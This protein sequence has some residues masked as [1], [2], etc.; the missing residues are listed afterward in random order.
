MTRSKKYTGVYYNTL[1][2]KDKSYYI[3][4]KNNSKKEW[5]KMGLHSEGIREA[6]CSKYRANLLIKLRL[7]DDAPTILKN[8]IKLT[9]N[10]I[11][12]DF[13]KKKSYSPKT[14]QSFWGRYINHI[15]PTLGEKEIT[16]ISDDD[17]KNLYTKNRTT[18]NLSKKTSQLTMEL[19][20]AII[21]HAIKKGNFTGTNPVKNIKIE[22]VD[23]ARE[24]YLS[25]GEIEIL[26]EQIKEYG[27]LYLFTLLSLSTGARLHD[28][29]ALQKKDFNLDNKTVTITNR[30]G[31]S[32]YQAFLTKRVLCTLNLSNLQH[33]DILYTVSERTIQRTLQNILNKLF[34]V[35]LDAK[36]AKN[37][38]VIHTLRHT[39]ASHLAIS[40][41][42]IYTIMK[43]MDHQ[44]IEDTLRYAKLS[45]ENGRDF[46]DGLF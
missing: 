41:T 12:T 8:T 17:C 9:L 32:T 37:R 2:N 31:K 35:G 40:G 46:V 20:G 36:D 16:A 43:L 11:T 27:N 45:P 30:K 19:L 26:L 34:N 14:H 39:F 10:D 42:P 3:T 1:E 13:F 24:R 28:I 15:H 6:Y 4:Y 7:G 29:Y 21:N 22:K 18:K 5:L 44:N 25:L 38:V 33:D 23:N